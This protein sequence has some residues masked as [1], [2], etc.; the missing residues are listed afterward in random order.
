MVGGAS[1]ASSTAPAGQAAVTAQA[2]ANNYRLTCNG[3]LR[4][5]PTGSVA[6]FFSSDQVRIQTNGTNLFDSGDQ[7][8]LN[9]SGIQDPRGATIPDP[10]ESFGVP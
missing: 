7:C 6:T 3:A 9:F 10:D 5:W 1:G 8:I 4:A 2:V